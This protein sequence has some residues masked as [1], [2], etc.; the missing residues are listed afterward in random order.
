MDGWKRPTDI[1]CRSGRPGRRACAQR[2]ALAA[3][4]IAAAWAGPSAASAGGAVG[5]GA[6]LPTEVSVGP[7]AAIQASPGTGPADRAPIGAPGWFVRSAAEGPAW[8]PGLD[9][10]PRDDAGPTD[11]IHTAGESADETKE[12]TGAATAGVERV[13]PE[14][15]RLPLGPAPDR[16]VGRSGRDAG[17]AGP[18]AIERA[19][20]RGPVGLL[21]E[22]PITRTAGALAVVMLLIVMMKIGLTRASR[23]GGSLRAQLG[24]GGRAPSG[25]LQVL[26]RYPVARGQTLVLLKLDARV[27]L[28][29]QT[30]AGFQ[31]LA[32]VSEASEVASILAKA[33]DDEGR[34]MSARFGQLLRSFEKDP[35]TAATEDLRV[36]ARSAAPGDEPAARFAA[37]RDRRWAPPGG[38]A[39][40]EDDG[41]I[42]P[43][44]RLRRRLAGLREMA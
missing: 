38:A 23:S 2:A 10:T 15:E 7:T 20:E 3:A 26:G 5:G 27:L 11:G 31:T 8:G 12:P 34:S 4:G 18:G 1:S 14:T 16:P 36:A 19:G 13:V 43:A 25:V 39:G 32:E 42:D 44:E 9:A 6:N 22:H 37:E 29:A 33:S 21:V 30:T 40:A 17:D 28:V 24:A 35:E 41:P